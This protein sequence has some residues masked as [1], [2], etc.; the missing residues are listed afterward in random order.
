[1]VERSTNELMEYMV[2]YEDEIEALR[3]SPCRLV[4]DGLKISNNNVVKETLR[5]GCSSRDDVSAVISLCIF[6]LSIRKKKKKG[7]EKNG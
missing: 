1:M 7:N 4:L 5:K 3:I 6:Q 2:W